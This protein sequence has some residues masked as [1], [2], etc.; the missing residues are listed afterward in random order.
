MKNLFLFVSLVLVTLFHPTTIFAMDSKVAKVAAKIT[1]GIV[2]GIKKSFSGEQAGMLNSEL[3]EVV[4]GRGGNSQQPSSFSNSRSTTASPSSHIV[5]SV[6]S[7]SH[8]HQIPSTSINLI[9]KEAGHFTTPEKKLPGSTNTSDTASESSLSQSSD[10]SPSQNSDSSSNSRISDASCSSLSSEKSLIV[11]ETMATDQATAPF[12]A[13]QSMLDHAL[14]QAEA[15][16]KYATDTINFI[17]EFFKILNLKTN[18]VQLSELSEVCEKVIAAKTAVDLVQINIQDRLRQLD[19]LFDSKIVGLAFSSRNDNTLFLAL[20]L[21]MNA[22]KETTEEAI[23]VTKKIMDGPVDKEKTLH[24]A[25]HFV[26]V[27]SFNSVVSLEKFMNLSTFSNI[28]TTKDALE[29]ALQHATITTKYAFITREAADKASSFFNN[30][31]EFSNKDLD[32]LSEACKAMDGAL[33]VITTIEEKTKERIRQLENLSDNNIVSESSSL[34]D[35]LLLEYQKLATTTLKETI[36]QVLIIAERV[37]NYEW[38]TVVDKIL[39]DI[40]NIRAQFLESY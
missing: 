34:N 24:L 29:K 5:T 27:P 15:T 36:K 17:Y 20:D 28:A 7:S 19:G 18:H 14:H 31:S 37:N 32:D 10:G 38:H 39:E 33:I 26:H 12:I 16:S 35:A 9:G 11:A 25:D 6:Q 2:T 1:E 22:I 3:D 30:I 40:A 23:A 4:E 21:A 8:D 13:T